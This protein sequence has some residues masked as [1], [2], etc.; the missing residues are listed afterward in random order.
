MTKEQT[1]P[2]PKGK[3]A[4]A[5]EPEKGST[6][7]TESGPVPP[8][9]PRAAQD[10]IGMTD[11]QVVVQ[12]IDLASSRGAFRGGELEVV[13]VL[14]NKLT[15]FLNNVKAAQEASQKTPKGDK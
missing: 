11:L 12:V 13:G 7:F 4:A 5:K 3:A 15:N 14:Y 8:T 1:K 9:T 10:S 2:A 6:E